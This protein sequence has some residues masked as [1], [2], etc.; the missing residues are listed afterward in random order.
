MAPILGFIGSSSYYMTNCCHD[1]LTV[2]R[3]ICS[4]ISLEFLLRFRPIQLG[5]AAPSRGEPFI[6]A[7]S[8]QLAKSM[9]YSVKRKQ[10]NEVV[11]IGNLFE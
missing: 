10:G 7:C 1:V 11:A 8:L 5:H 2:G 4:V 6:G 9:P 3:Q